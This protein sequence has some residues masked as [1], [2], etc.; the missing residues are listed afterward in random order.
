[1][2]G[3]IVSPQFLIVV[4]SLIQRVLTIALINFIIIV[5]LLH[6][7]SRLLVHGLEAGRW[8]NLLAISSVLLLTVALH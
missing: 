5:I 6:L 8:P 4:S 2:H 1:M 3:E 7:L